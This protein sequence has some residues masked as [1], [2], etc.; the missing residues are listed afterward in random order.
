[1]CFIIE[2]GYYVES[3]VRNRLDVFGRVF[4]FDGFRHHCYIINI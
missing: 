3:N 2:I 1:M 4:A